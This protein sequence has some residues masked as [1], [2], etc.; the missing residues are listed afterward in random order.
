VG[1]G[2]TNLMTVFQNLSYIQITLLRHISAAVV[3]KVYKP[4]IKQQGISTPIICCLKENP[5]LVPPN[6]Q[7]FQ[8]LIVDTLPQNNKIILKHQILKAKIDDT[9]KKLETRAK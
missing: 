9:K 7:R 6:E 4:F 5:I 2:G 1:Q 8:F 3:N